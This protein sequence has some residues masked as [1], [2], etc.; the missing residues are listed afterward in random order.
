MAQVRTKAGNCDASIVTIQS[1]PC[2]TCSVLTIAGSA[3]VA[4]FAD[5]V[6]NA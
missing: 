2:E 1:I 4:G 6:G 5:G 3:G